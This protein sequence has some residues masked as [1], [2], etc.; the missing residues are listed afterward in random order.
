MPLKKIKAFV[1]SA[2]SHEGKFLQVIETIP[3]YVSWISEDDKY[4]RVNSRL[5]TA[6]NLAVEDFVGKDIG[7]IK[8]NSIFVTVLKEF[9]ASKDSRFSREIPIEFNSEIRWHLLIAERSKNHS[10][11]LVI[12]IDITAR[13][14]AEEAL[15]QS[16]LRFRRLIEGAPDAICVFSGERLIYANPRMATVLGYAGVVDLIDQP[17]TS[18]VAAE[19]L[20]GFRKRTRFAPSVPAA[21]GLCEFRLM[22]KSGEIVQFE[23]AVMLTEFEGVPSV[24][25]FARDISLRQEMQELIAAKKSAEEA[26]GLKK[27]FISNISHEIRTPMNGVMGLTDLLLKTELTTEQREYLSAIKNSAENLLVIINDVLDFEKLEAGKM[28][29]E[30]VPFKITDIIDLVIELQLP[31]SSEKKISLEKYYDPKMSAYHM[32][33]PVRMNQI[34]TNLLGNAIKFTESG[35][36]SVSVRVASETPDNQVLEFEIA[37]TGIGIPEDKVAIVFDSFTQASDDV[38]RKYGGTGLGLSIVKDLVER[39][40]GTIQVTSKVGVGTTIQVRIPYKKAIPGAVLQKADAAVVAKNIGPMNILLAEDNPIN[41]LIAKKVLQ[42]FGFSVEVAENGNVALEKLQKQPFDLVI[43]DVQMPQMDGLTATRR[44]RSECPSPMSTIPILAMTA[45]ASKDEL[46]ECL[47]AGMNDSV[48]KPFRADVLLQKILKVTGRDKRQDIRKSS[49]DLAYLKE[50][51]GDD[52][53]GIRQMLELF[54]NKAPKLVESLQLGLDQSDWRRVGRAAHDMRSTFGYL[55]IQ[56]VS[57]AAKE[58]EP[59]T[60]NITDSEQLKMKIERLLPLAKGAI[61]EAMALSK[62]FGNGEKKLAA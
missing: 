11:L 16:E 40:Q 39:H 45:Y 59:M 58:I 60:K 35:K 56:L 19:D 38:T 1:T 15:K 18:I 28:T 8:G 26:L 46:D 44:I 13:K 47:K 4:I 49:V 2:I 61:S 27:K 36:V 7:F 34:I 5:A 12:G 57:E 23:I 52:V 43:M 3:A 62:T 20:E 29:L 41:Q 50:T 24:L 31:R 17:L 25:L 32:G 55:G 22:T 37:D 6:H 21:E 30:W 14:V 33:D 51:L 9:R 53:E 48:T 54:L 42:G 10:E